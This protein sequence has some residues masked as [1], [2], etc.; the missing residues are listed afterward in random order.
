MAHV[1][2]RSV[3][4]GTGRTIAPAPVGWRLAPATPVLTGLATGTNPVTIAQLAGE[5]TI[6]VNLLAFDPRH[7]GYRI[8]VRLA[9]NALAECDLRSVPAAEQ[10]RHTA[11]ITAARAA[12]LTL[13]AAA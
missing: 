9:A 8:K 10:A 5:L 7:P 1:T 11:A 12:A 6:A 3:R 2:S 4:R 13:A